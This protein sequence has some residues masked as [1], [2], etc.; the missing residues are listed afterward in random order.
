MEIELKLTEQEVNIVLQV[1]GQMPSSS[2]VYPLMMK[3]K[4]MA[5]ASIAK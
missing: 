3:I 5:E 2:G 4:Q 1:L